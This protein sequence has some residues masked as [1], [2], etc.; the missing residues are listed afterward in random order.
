MTLR[1]PVKFSE[2]FMSARQ[3]DREGRQARMATPAEFSRAATA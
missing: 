1:L 3:F 2:V